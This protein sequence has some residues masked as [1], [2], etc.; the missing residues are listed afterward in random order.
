MASGTVLPSGACLGPLSSSY[1]TDSF[2]PDNLELCPLSA[3]APP[4]LLRLL[5]GNPLWY[6]VHTLAL[7]PRVLCLV[8][9]IRVFDLG[10]ASSSLRD[11]L[12]WFASPERG[13]YYALARAVRVTISPSLYLALVILVKRLVVGP[14]RE[15]P[16][17]PWSA[18]QT[19]LMSALL[20]RKRL[21]AVSLLL[22]RHFEGISTVYRWLGAKVGRRVD[23]PGAGP[24]IVGTSTLT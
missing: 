18:F 23:W 13:M 6:L 12:H 14:F 21:S 9:L 24:D 3:T 20:P 5:I 19:W 17:T 2:H 16:R 11:L 8:M 15:G 7:V 1:E 10:S 22:G 4:L